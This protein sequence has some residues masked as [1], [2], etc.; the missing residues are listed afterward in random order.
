MAM[1]LAE[2]K[3]AK[4]ELAKQERELQQVEVAKLGYNGVGFVKPESLNSPNGPQVQI[5]F[6]V[7]IPE[8][9]TF[10]EL[11][12]KH[13]SINKALLAILPKKTDQQ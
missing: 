12:A 10:S 9:L 2:L 8:A 11:V 3:R 6:S 4:A 1:T 5:T 13:G 7:G